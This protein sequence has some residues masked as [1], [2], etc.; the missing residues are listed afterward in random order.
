LL[1]D[2]TEI[3]DSG[4]P[5]SPERFNAYLKKLGLPPYV[6]RAGK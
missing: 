1:R 5:V 4:M 6:K 3:N 2:L